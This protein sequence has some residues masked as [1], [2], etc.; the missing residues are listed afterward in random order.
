MPSAC[1]L[2]VT[3]PRAPL[4]DASERLRSAANNTTIGEGDV[5]KGDR[6]MAL[7]NPGGGVYKGD[8]GVV[9]RAGGILSGYNDVSFN[10]T[11]RSGLGDN[12]VQRV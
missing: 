8:V 2:C 3:R 9:T 7:R 6:V 1:H 4:G 5:E 10:G 11:V 12:D